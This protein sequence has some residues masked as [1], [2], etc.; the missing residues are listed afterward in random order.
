MKPRIAHAGPV[1]GPSEQAERCPHCLQVYV[2]EVGT[3][4]AVCDEPICPFC[5]LEVKG[6][7]VCPACHE[8]D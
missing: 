5:V 8:E 1:P 7:V 4:C 3:Y 6:E 2:L